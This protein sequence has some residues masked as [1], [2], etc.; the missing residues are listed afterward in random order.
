MGI[1][2]SSDSGASQF[3]RQ[4]MNNENKDSS[5]ISE[6]GRVHVLSPA[7]AGT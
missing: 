5:V 4:E 3:P 6:E 2:R 1:D 7:T